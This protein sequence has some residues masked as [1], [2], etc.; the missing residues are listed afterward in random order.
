M[1]GIRILAE[2]MSRIAYVRKGSGWVLSRVVG[3]DR[4]LVDAD[5]A[6]VRC[7]ICSA[8]QFSTWPT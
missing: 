2:G 4:R 7:L 8:T 1:W 6:V 3:E 5:E